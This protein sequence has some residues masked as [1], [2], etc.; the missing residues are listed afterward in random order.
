MRDAC[1][2]GRADDVKA[3]IEAGYSIHLPNLRGTYPVWLATK[4]GHMDI[5][6]MLIAARAPLDAEVSPFETSLVNC[7]YRR[8]LALAKMLLDAK[9]DVHGPWGAGS[10]LHVAAKSG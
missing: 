2:Q 6:Q 1:I 8:D 4:H 3:L 5:T 10:A 7:I 9:A